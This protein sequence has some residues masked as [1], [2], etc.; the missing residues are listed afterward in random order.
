MLSLNHG[1]APPWLRRLRNLKRWV[2]NAAPPGV[3][4]SYPKSGRT[5]LRVILQDL[6]V[7]LA[8]THDGSSGSKARKFEELKPIRKELYT[9]MPVVFLFRDPRDTVV[10]AYFWETHRLVDGYAGSMAEF[11][12]DPSHG[13]EKIVRFNLAWLEQGPKSPG[14]SPDQI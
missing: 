2:T 6:D 9:E 8:F 3:I 10:S 11:I 7:P 13:V 4:V 1:M 12:R 14:L 5:W